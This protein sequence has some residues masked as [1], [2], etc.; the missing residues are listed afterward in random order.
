MS[1][2][3]QHPTVGV[4]IGVRQSKPKIRRLY[5][6][7]GTSFL[8]LGWGDMFSPNEISI[9]LDDDGLH[10]LVSEIGRFSSAEIDAKSSEEAA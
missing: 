7:D 8:V 3:L 6:S 9:H 5:T 4:T 1:E 10:A 2:I